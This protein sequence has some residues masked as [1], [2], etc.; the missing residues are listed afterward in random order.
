MKTLRPYQLDA[1]TAIERSLSSSRSTLV[2]MPTG[3]GKTVTIGSYAVKRDVRTLW[4]AHRFELLTQARDYLMDATGEPVGME[5]ADSEATDE[6][7][8]VASV[9]SMCRQ[10]R[11]KRY[12]VDH[13][14]LIVVDEAHHVT[15]SS[16]GKILDHFSSAQ[17][18][19]CT[20]TPD[21]L[22]KVRLGL[23]FD[24]VA[25]K[26]ELADAIRDGWLCRILAEHV[27]VKSIDL[28][29][30]GIQADDFD[31][32]DLDEVMRSREAIHG[33]VKPCLEKCGD[34][35]TFVFTTSV[36][37]ADIM[38]EVF[39]AYRPGCARTANGETDFAVR[40]DLLVQHSKGAFQFFV[41]VG[42]H[43]EGVDAPWVSCVA[44]GRP[45]KSR[46]LVTQMVG[47][48][49]RLCEGKSNLLVLD[50]SGNLGRHRLVTIADI[51][52]GKPRNAA[53]ARIREQRDGSDVLEL[54]D[55]DE[56]AE[57]ERLRAD[58]LIRDQ[59]DAERA[60]LLRA[61]VRYE[62]VTAD[63][64][65]TYRINPES[66]LESLSN[67]PDAGQLARFK[68]YGIPVPIDLTKSAAKAIL[69]KEG[70]RRHF[71]WSTFGQ[72]QFLRRYNIDGHSMRYHQ[73]SSK[74]AEIK[75]GMHA[76]PG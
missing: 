7:L 45:S 31:P 33:V 12:A 63:L 46:A 13:F 52:G 36:A 66:Y 71:G 25:Y 49:T 2:V 64:F 65:G 44:L 68:K 6:R 75:K 23:R 28:S 3:T 40:A 62:C 26:M 18:I 16:Y 10:S 57:R 61:H 73:A 15:G 48:G 43:T 67:S 69:A 1:H 32:N 27:N 55:N 47:R 24:S 39:N 41:S 38:T 42:I 60:A 35:P 51:L 58:R 54:I 29:M 74:I 11:L 70:Q 21:R 56:R 37:N 19:G 14:G 76:L 5:Q 34:R 8:I 22:D 72:T 30:V 53:V 20:A 9:Q 4:L 17:V 59:I 50:F